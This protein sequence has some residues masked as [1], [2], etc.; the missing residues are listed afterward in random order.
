[1]QREPFTTGELD[2]IA[3]DHP[4]GWV[5]GAEPMP[6][7]P[8]HGDPASNGIIGRWLTPGAPVVGAH[9]IPLLFPQL[10]ERL[11]VESEQIQ[12]DVVVGRVDPELRAARV[13]GPAPGSGFLAELLA[14]A[15]Q[16]LLSWSSSEDP[17]AGSWFGRLPA[18]TRRRI[19]TELLERLRDGTLSSTHLAASA[20]I[21]L[22]NERDGALV[23][24]LALGLL[25][26]SS[27]DRIY[28][29]TALQKTFSK[30][31]APSLLEALKDDSSRV[32]DAATLALNRLGNY[33]DEKEKWEKR[34][35][36]KK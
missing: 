22:G 30:D 27:T 3:I 15:E 5:G 13:V 33:F 1:M 21:Q 31:A 19:C 36:I 20:V 26:P 24:T 23:G 18:E 4:Q 16:R 12:V 10:D 11:F 35:G 8:A 25:L 32:V 17:G 34:F 28:A 2:R 14:A 7:C 9:L 29:V 6:S